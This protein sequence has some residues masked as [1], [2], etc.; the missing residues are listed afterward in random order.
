[1]TYLMMRSSRFASISLALVITVAM[2]S[3][4]CDSGSSETTAEASEQGASSDKTAP[5]DAAEGEWCKGHGLPESHCTECHPELIDKFKEAGDWCAEHGFPESACPECNPMSP[6]GDEDVK[7]EAQS[8][9]QGEWCTGHGLPESHCTKCHPELIDKFKEAGDWCAEHGFPESACPTCNPMDPPAPEVPTGSIAAIP[10]V[11][12]G[13]QVVFKQADHEKAVGIETSP[14]REVP[15]GLG[16]RAPARIEFDRNHFADVRAAVP[17][18]VRDVVI[19]L[20]Q[21]VERGAPLFVLESAHVG[22]VQGKIHAAKE[23]LKT[24]RAEL[25]RQEKLAKKGLTPTRKA[26]LAR[27]DFAESKSR[28]RSLESSLRLAGGS[29]TSSNGRYTLR[30]PI[31]GTVV[32]RPGVVGA[33][34]TDKT[35]LATITDTGTMW[36]MMDVSEKDSFALANGQ[37][38]VFTV[39]GATDEA[40]ESLEFQG[41]VT[42][43]APQVDSRTRTVKVRAEIDNSDGKLRANQF[44]RAEIGIAPD[45]K[46]VVVPKEAV[47]RLDEGTVVFVRKKQGTYEPRVVEAGRS[48]GKVV[49]VRGNLE[50]G[51]AVVTTGAFILKTELSKDSIGAGCCEVPE[52]EE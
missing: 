2:S 26:E 51:E 49:Q 14:A 5:E 18:I 45:K 50:A 17:G 19:D 30:A 15:V 35:S 31:D 48:D 27:Q 16:T 47:Q 7:P 10:S 39:D 29:G 36:A 25:E 1:M 44:A 28:L 3:I 32:A 43:I 12:P 4:G 13:T 9:A 24:A 20:G 22:E 42:W 8:A 33:F 52:Q 38:V 21:S 23:E 46:G 40:G 37:P 41:V 11:E 6:P 34:A